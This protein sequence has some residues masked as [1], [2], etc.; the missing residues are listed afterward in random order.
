MNSWVVVK[1]RSSFGI[2]GSFGGW[3]IWCVERL[4][5]SKDTQSG[6]GGAG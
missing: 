1:E 6:S 2:F 4:L 3:W 5:V